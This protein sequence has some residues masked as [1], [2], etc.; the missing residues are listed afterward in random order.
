M[1][2]AKLQNGTVVR[3]KVTGYEG[4]I[5]GTTEIKALF[6]ERGELLKKPSSKQ[7]FQYRV[8]VEGESLRRIAPVEDFEILEGTVA[9]GRRKRATKK[10][11][12]QKKDGLTTG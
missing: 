8:M 12:S 5:D 1:D 9:I 7:T 3:H 4:C 2:E 10:S 11:S 6:T